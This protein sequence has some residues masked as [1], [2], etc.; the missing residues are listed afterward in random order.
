MILFA[1]Q[2]GL[3]NWYIRRTGHQPTPQARALGSGTADGEILGVFIYDGWNGASCEMHMAGS[4]GWLT[5]KFLWAAFDY[6]FNK[7]GCKV[8]YT[9]IGSGNVRSLKIVKGFG[10]KEV[11]RIP[12]AHPDGALVIVSL[13]KEDCK[14]IKEKDHG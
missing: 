14:W 2:V 10:A 4:E 5:K 13:T 8:V 3:I 9:V 12:S 7:C 11:A 1:D 6:P